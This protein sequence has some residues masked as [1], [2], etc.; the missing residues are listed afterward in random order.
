MRGPPK[1]RGYVKCLHTKYLQFIYMNKK[2]PHNFVY[3]KGGLLGVSPTN[4]VSFHIKNFV[5]RAGIPA[6]VRRDVQRVSA[7]E[8]QAHAMGC[9]FAT[10]VQAARVN[11]TGVNEVPHAVD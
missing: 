7:L 1:E 11:L 4:E 8:T 5:P 6:R 3:E 9:V 10:V 2:N